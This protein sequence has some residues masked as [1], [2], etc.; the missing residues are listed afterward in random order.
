MWCKLTYLRRPIKIGH[1]NSE[2]KNNKSANLSYF[3]LALSQTQVRKFSFF[4]INFKFLFSRGII[5]LFFHSFYR[6]TPTTLLLIQKTLFLLTV[7]TRFNLRSRQLCCLAP[8][9]PSA[10]AREVVEE[11]GDGYSMYC[12]REWR[13]E[14]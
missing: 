2:H 11:E 3:P 9:M 14:T 8:V 13:W 7:F 4:W 10:A 5:E 12:N 6:C 1:V